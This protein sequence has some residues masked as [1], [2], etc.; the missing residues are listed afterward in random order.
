MRE[1]SKGK[2]LRIDEAETAELPLWLRNL[3][4]PKEAKTTKSTTQSVYKYQ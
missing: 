1:K 3:L 2:N 4:T